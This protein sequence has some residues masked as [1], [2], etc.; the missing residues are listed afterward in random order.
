[1]KGKSGEKGEKGRG[2]RGEG[3]ERSREGELGVSLAQR[4]KILIFIFSFLF[5]STTVPSDL[6]WNSEHFILQQ[7]PAR[8]CHCRRA[9][10]H[11]GRLA[12]FDALR[13]SAWK[14][15]REKKKMNK[16][17]HVPKGKSG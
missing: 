11:G 8:W 17:T 13:F 9:R 14:G 16:L 4:C 7:S 1:M 3:E 2:E 12:C 6:K 5:S 10:A 15:T